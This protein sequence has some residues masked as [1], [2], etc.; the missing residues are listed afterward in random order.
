MSKIRVRFAPSPTGYLHVGGARTALFNWLFARHNKGDFILRIED[1][2]QIRSTDQSID[3]IMVSLQWLGI[4]WDEYYRQSERSDLHQRAAEQLLDAGAV[5]EEEGAL[6]FKVPEQGEIMVNDLLAG[7]VI[8]ANEQL[9][10]FVIRRSDGSFTYNFACVVDD[11]DLHISHVIRGDEHLNNTPRQIL[12]YHALGMPVPKFVHLPMILGPD[13]TKLSKRLGATSVLDYK[14]R[15]FLPTA[16][17]N[18]FARLGW[19]HGDQE[20]FTKQEL[21]DLFGLTAIGTS[22]AIFDEEKLLWLNGRHIKLIDPEKLVALVEPFV[23][24]AKIADQ[25]QWQSIEHARLVSIVTLLRDRSHT[26][27]DLATAMAILF[28]IT[29][30][31]DAETARQ[32]FSPDKINL[33]EGIIAALQPLDQFTAAAI[34]AQL[35]VVAA[36]QGVKLKD[37]AQPCRYAVTGQTVGPGLFHLL[38]VIGK[39]LTLQ[40]L[41]DRLAAMKR[42]G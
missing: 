1:T 22:A 33:M 23:I 6:W 38:E 17:L 42:D 29:L 16:L 19:S 30:D 31:Y 4:D 34:E 12:L 9:K 35:R 37:I 10:D 14:A 20:V 11:S 36:E 28:P 26:L 39:E 32:Y 3:E 27:I 21:I 40:R 41:S 13:K 25:I 7:T 2:D 18:F 24:E 5:Y 15:G 8:F